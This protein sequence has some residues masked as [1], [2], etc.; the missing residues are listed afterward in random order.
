[1]SEET[2]FTRFRYAIPMTLTAATL[3]LFNMPSMNHVPSEN[4]SLP[5]FRLANYPWEEGYIPSET[6]FSPSF[7]GVEAIQMFAMNLLEEMIDIPP[8][9]SQVIDENFWDLV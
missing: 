9:F 6:D 2:V 8:E 1:M 3:N 4:F 5:N 7:N